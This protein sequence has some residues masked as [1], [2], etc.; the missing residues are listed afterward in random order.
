MESIKLF[1]KA[2]IWIFAIY[3]LV[4]WILL[5]L[6]I[7]GTGFRLDYLAPIQFYQGQ[8]A[9]YVALVLLGTGAVIMSVGAYQL[10]HTGKGLPIS[11]LP[12]VTLVQN[13]L[14][15]YWRHPMYIGYTF[16]LVGLSIL[17]GS[18]WTL[19]ICIPLFI[20]GWIVYIIF[21]EEPILV[22]RFPVA[23]PE[24]RRRIAIFIP[25]QI[26][27]R[28]MIN[29]GRLSAK[30][31]GQL[32]KLADWTVLFRKGD[33]IF[34]TYGLFIAVGGFFYHILL[35]A[36]LLTQGLNRTEIAIFIVFSAAS[37]FLTAK[38]FWWLENSSALKAQSWFG[39]RQIGFVSWGG[40]AGI[41]V[42]VILFSFWYGY[43]ILMI[44][45]AVIRSVL[46][47]WAIGRFGCLTYGCCCGLP[48]KGNGIVYS[49]INS[50]IVREKGGSQPPRYPTPVYSALHCLFIV[51][52]LNSI[53]VFLQLPVGF[54]TAI[55]IILYSVGRAIIEYF[56]E[57]S[58]HWFGQLSCLTAF[59]IG[60]LLLFFL[61]PEIGEF[62]PHPLSIST[63]FAVLPI[64]PVLVIVSLLAFLSTGLHRKKMGFV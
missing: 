12:P 55:G 3:L 41:G 20:A 6:L 5:P 35:S 30:I 50:T 34:V 47:A 17:V 52:F 14:Y 40:F 44:S 22:S 37:V 25:N 39:L 49:N 18:V 16:S 11:H 53:I 57:R 59:C 62:S 54:I 2:R 58:L 51:V 9:S 21:Y 23:Y 43:P 38:A 24:Y 19:V 46:I 60:W 4:F 48:K 13:G 45:D 26:P 56:R 63:I 42:S 28:G 32:N 61:S 31:Y 10:L 8:L 7:F 29:F 36:L 1:P 27:G 64:L 33:F 15:K